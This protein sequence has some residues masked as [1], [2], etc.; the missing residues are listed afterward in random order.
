MRPLL[1]MRAV[2][3]TFTSAGG[4]VTALAGLDLDLWPGEMVALMGPS[5]SGKSTALAIAGLLLSPT[6]GQLEIAGAP[7]PARE[8]ERARLRNSVLGY[9]HQEFAV[10][11]DLSGVDNVRIPLD[12]AR[13]RARKKERRAAASSL[14]ARLG[15]AEDV[16]GRRTDTMS[17]G[18]RQRVAIGRALVNDPRIVLADEPTASL[19]SDAAADVVGLFAECRDAGRGVLLATHDE[20]VAKKC[21]RVVRMRDGTVV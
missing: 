20:R 3:R 16:A 19:D 6:S 18:Q 15:L 13:P 4:A 14:L 17:G 10:I 7:A 12:Y 5:G 8:N 2:V 9:V 1:R 11:E 21:D